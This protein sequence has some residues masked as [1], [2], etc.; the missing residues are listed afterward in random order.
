MS[1]RSTLPIRTAGSKK[2][3]FCQIN[4]ILADDH[5]IV[6]QGL[7]AVL[8]AEGDIAVVGEAADGLDA[9]EIAEKLKPDVMV[10]DIMMP[11][12]IGLEAVRQIHSRSPRTKCVVLSMHANDAYVLEALRNGATGYVLKGADSTEMVNAVRMAS[13]GERYLSPEIASDSVEALLVRAQ[14]SRVEDVYET[15][16][17]R[18][19]EVFQLAAEGQTNIAIAERL[20]ISARTVEIHRANLLKKIGL[21]TQTD[22]VRFAMR[23]G[24]LPME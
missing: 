4:V 21:K 11:G 7:R 17:T 2:G 13:R 22:L 15:L 24:M 1:M 9:V 3:R 12:I 20:F 5:P 16:T 23:R 18:E 19:R 14:A 6:R 10:I 8:E